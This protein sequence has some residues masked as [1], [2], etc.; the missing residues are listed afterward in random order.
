M[1]V[2]CTSFIRNAEAA[3]GQVASWS[4]NWETTQSNES[5]VTSSDVGQRHI[6]VTANSH[7]SIE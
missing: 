3:L 2:F 6:G 5:V 7:I 4:I 1:R